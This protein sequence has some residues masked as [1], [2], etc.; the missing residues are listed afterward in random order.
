MHQI[1]IVLLLSV[2]QPSV[3]C[4]NPTH[5]NTNSLEIILADCLLN[6]AETYFNPD[7]P[8]L[9]QLATD[10]SLASV[11]MFFRTTGE[12]TLK[13]LVQTFK[14]TIINFGIIYTDIVK[15]Y[16]RLKPGSVLLILPNLRI[17]I[18]IILTIRELLERMRQIFGDSAL[19]FVIVITNVI[20][21]KEIKKQTVFSVLQAVWF[22]QKVSS[23]IVLM[24]V[25]VKS[26][27]NEKIFVIDVYSW[28]PER[29]FNEESAE[30]LT[31]L[32][33]VEHFDRWISN[34]KKFLKNTNL[35]PK[36][37]LK[38]MNN[39]TLNVGSTIFPPFGGFPILVMKHPNP[40]LVNGLYTGIIKVLGQLTKVN[41]TTRVIKTNTWNIFCPGGVV[42]DEGRGYILQDCKCTRAHF[43]ASIYWYLSTSSI[44]Q[45]QSIIRVFSTPMWGLVGISYIMGSITFWLRGGYHNNLHGFLDAFFDTFRSYLAQ[46]FSQ[47]FNG[48]ISATF[49]S[50]WLVF[51]IQVYTSY[52]TALIGFLID[53]GDFS[54]IKSI[55]ELEV[56]NIELY[57]GLQLG[58]RITHSYCNIIECMNILTNKY[59]VAILGDSF[60]FDVFSRFAPK[61]YGR[62]RMYK[63]DM[64]YMDIPIICSAH[65]GCMFTEQ[66]NF[67]TESL[68]T[69]GILDKWLSDIMNQIERENRNHENDGAVPLSLANLQG[70][71]YVLIVGLLLASVG[72]ISELMFEYLIT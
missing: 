22:Y 47:K 8:V 24:P 36:K 64:K 2:N 33:V 71:F 27:E 48:I 49:I 32:T 51:C 67:V 9:I 55:E 42:F 20:K 19:R 5:N 44:P 28:L 45:W 39:C 50:L 38:S 31:N 53:P 72:F 6:I 7:M 11:N 35:F 43:R 52:Q 58:K 26:S 18:K 21:S 12:L 65:L 1:V 17:L 14:Y 25:I 60:L 40:E 3:L 4:A 66:L 29:Q 34:E 63:L 23:V 57:S 59:N 13:L 68:L 46:S 62:K 54:Q 10:R 37:Q 16:Y 69:A 61:R 70:P 56:K 30:C 41:F 15:L